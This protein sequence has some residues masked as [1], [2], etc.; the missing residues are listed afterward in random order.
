MHDSTDGGYTKDQ[1]IAAAMGWGGGVFTTGGGANQA[2]HTSATGDFTATEL[3]L[4]TDKLTT[5]TTQIATPAQTEELLKLASDVAN[6]T[7][8]KI[9]IKPGE[10]GANTPKSDFIIEASILKGI[11]GDLRTFREA[12]NNE[13]KKINQHL[14]AVETALKFNETASNLEFSVTTREAASTDKGTQTFNC[15]NKQ[16]SDC[17]GKCVLEGGVCKPKKKGEG[18]NKEKDGKAAST[19]AGKEEKIA[20]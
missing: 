20:P 7:F 4:C 18:E 13:E 17:T 6:T 2:Y 1:Q 9:T 15:K 5:L 11:H 19:C 14:N 3:A 10:L 8:N 16:G 12:N